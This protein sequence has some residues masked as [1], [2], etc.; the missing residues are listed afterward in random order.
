MQNFTATVEPK[1]SKFLHTLR[2][3]GEIVATRTSARRYEFI[4]IQRWGLVGEDKPMAYPAGSNA[5]DATQFAPR[6]SAK[7]KPVGAKIEYGF[8]AQNVAIVEVA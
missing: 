2:L 4:H 8:N 1:G 5:G 6:Y 3:D 7:P